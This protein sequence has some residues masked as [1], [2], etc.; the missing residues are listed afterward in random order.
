MK[1]E[2]ESLREEIERKKEELEQLELQEKLGVKGSEIKDLSEFTDFEKC[3]FFDDLYKSSLDRL[4]NTIENGYD[5]DDDE[6]Y[7]WEECMLI[8]ARDKDSFWTYYNKLID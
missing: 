4:D 5:D 6:H 3:K 1:R 2:I 7:A 8:L